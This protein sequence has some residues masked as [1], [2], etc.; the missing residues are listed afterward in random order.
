MKVAREI[1]YPTSVSV[2][3]HGLKESFPW[4]RKKE[5]EIDIIPGDYATCTCMYRYIWTLLKI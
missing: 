3:T 4:K 5:R 2:E 1:K